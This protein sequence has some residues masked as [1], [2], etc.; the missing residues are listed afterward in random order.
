[1]HDTTN[2][3]PWFVDCSACGASMNAMTAP[4]CHCVTKRPNLVC[5]KCG[6]CLCRNGDAA[7][8]KFW[9]GAPHEAR[10]RRAA[11]VRARTE[12]AAQHV[13]PGGDVLVVDDDEE[14]RLI[15][16]F[17]LQQIG[18]VVSVAHDPDEVL[19]IVRERPPRVVLT[20][21]LMPRMDGRELCKRIKAI[22]GEVQVVIMTSLYTGA[23]YRSEAH[24]VF[25][26]DGYVAKPIDFE[27]LRRILEKLAPLSSRKVVTA[28]T[29]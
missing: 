3:A 20:D 9:F 16:S 25:H 27:Q 21:A 1:M 15:A 11:E 22:D 17:M 28:V 4:W 14:I 24:R 10:E 7:A 2:D 23:R 13:G 12:W 29:A 8:L 19:K 26:A 6:H 18:Y 5:A